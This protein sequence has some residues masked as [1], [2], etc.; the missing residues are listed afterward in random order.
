MGCLNVHITN[1]STPINAVI[2][3]I[4]R[5][6]AL[7]SLYE[8]RLQCKVTALLEPLKVVVNYSGLTINV[9]E[10]SD[11]ISFTASVVCDAINNYLNVAEGVIQLDY[12]GNSV[13]VSVESNTTWTIDYQPWQDGN[14]S[15]SYSGNGNGLAT[16]SSD[17]N[18]GVDRETIATFK[19]D[20]LSVQRVVSQIGMREIFNEDFILADSGTFNVLK[21]G[22]R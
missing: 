9:S 20:N 11:R 10:I 18:E 5:I 22:I 3:R 2:T 14:L 21:D 19:A 16:F 17:A 15:V 4:G 6:N 1:L 7:V 8:S 13:S 12:V